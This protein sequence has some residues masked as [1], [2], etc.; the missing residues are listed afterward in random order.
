M[1]EITQTIKSVTAHKINR[2]L[3]RSG[4]FWLHESYDRI[5]RNDHEYYATF[6]YIV[7]NPVAAGLARRPEDW[8]WGGP[9]FD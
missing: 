3:R 5:I 8:L 9:P 6:D 1:S 4:S 7:M 2:L